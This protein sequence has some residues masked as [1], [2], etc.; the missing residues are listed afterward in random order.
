MLIAKHAIANSYLL[1][2]MNF[3]RKKM[4]IITSKVKMMSLLQFSKLCQ[5]VIQ[6]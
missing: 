6:D 4:F 3:T 1:S 5:T 2:W